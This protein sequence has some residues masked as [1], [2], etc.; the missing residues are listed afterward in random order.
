MYFIGNLLTT[1]AEIL[2]ALLLVYMAVLIAAAILSW[3]QPDP[4]NPLVRLLRNLT[5]P[6][7]DKLRK[8]VP[9]IGGLDLT[10]VV[11]IVAILLVKGWLLASLA[12]FG[13]DLSM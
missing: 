9:L 7:L 6:A 4:L 1:V 10:P 5:E 12:R 2:D 13:R 8:H 11:M 3:V